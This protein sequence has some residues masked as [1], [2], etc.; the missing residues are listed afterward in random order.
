[1]EEHLV[2]GQVVAEE[3]EGLGER[4][5]PQLHLGTSPAD[6]GEG[7]EALEDPDGVV[8]GEH[9]HAGAQPQPRG[10]PGDR[11]EHHVWRGDGVVVAVVLPEPEVVD[12]DLVGEDPFGDDLADGLGLVHGSP[13]GSELEVAEGVEPEGRVLRCAQAQQGVGQGGGRGAHAPSLRGG[14]YRSLT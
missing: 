12:P 8:R 11:G 7:G 6:G 3:R 1:M 10:L 2:V 13:V 14:L 9:R 5:T 4:A